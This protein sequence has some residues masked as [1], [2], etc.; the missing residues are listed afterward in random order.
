M[1]GR[2]SRAGGILN[3]MEKYPLL[4]RFIAHFEDSSQ[5]YP[6]LYIYLNIFIYI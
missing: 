3:P 5:K 1:V 2:A 4:V 6:Y